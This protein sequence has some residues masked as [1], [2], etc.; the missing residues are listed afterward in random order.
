MKNKFYFF[1]KLSL[2]LVYLVIV[3]GAI[4]RVTGSGM[5]CPDWPK[6]FGYILPPT[7]KSHLEWKAN[8]NY[9]KNQMIIAYDSLMVAKNNFK[10]NIRYERSN[11]SKY[12]KHDHST[13]NVYNTW[14][15]FI[16]RF[17]GLISGFSTLLMLFFSISFW[18]KNKLFFYG[19]LIVVLAMAFQAIL[20]KEVVD[21]NL[22]PVKVTIHMIMALI[23]ICLLISILFFINPKNLKKYPDNNILTLTLIAFLITFFQIVSGT[24]VRQFID[25]Q[26]INHPLQ[27]NLWLNPSPSIFYLHRSFS[28]IVLF[29][30]FMLLKNFTKV[31]EIPKTL[32]FILIAIG[33][34][35]ITGITMYYINFPI[36]SQPIHLLLASLILGAQLYLIL[37]IILKRKIYD[38]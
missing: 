8:F 20:G 30:H 7:K 25:L 26:M 18:K 21:S 2:L 22:L 14:I 27:K 35:V 5:G 9:K 17:L 37:Q 3:A 34:E 12:L 38:I 11:W 13:F 6:C 23:I 19:S 24:Q 10:S 4:V 33:L 31:G 29:V 1:T 36:S 16:N 32:K 28:L 15:E